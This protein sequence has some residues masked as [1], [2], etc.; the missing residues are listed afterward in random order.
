[1]KFT[2]FFN[3]RWRVQ[4]LSKCL[5]ALI[6]KTNDHSNLEFIVKADDDDEPTINYLKNLQLPFKFGHIVSP[7]PY[8]LNASINNMALQASGQYLFHINDD[9]EIETQDWDVIAWDKIQQFKKE[10]N[11]KDDIIYGWVEDN[12]ADKDR[13]AN[14]ASFPIVSRQAV[15]ILKMFM[16][17]VFLSHGPDPYIYRIYEAVERVVDMREIVLNHTYHKTIYDVNNPDQTNIDVRKRAMNYNI[18][19]QTMSIEKEVKTLKDFIHTC[20]LI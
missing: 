1:M 17:A 10:N 3:S 7:R 2:V 19:P 5:Q 12:S 8:S 6:D 4:Q 16:P 14:Y 9:A 15:H 20:K 18:N 13:S 11:I